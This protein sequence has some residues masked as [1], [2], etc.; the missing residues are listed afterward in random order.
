[1]QNFRTAA[2]P[3]DQDQMEI[4]PIAYRLWQ[5]AGRPPGR[6]KEF[7]VEAQQ[8]VMAARKAQTDAFVS[9][10]RGAGGPL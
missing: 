7:W 6:Y 4:A 10:A 2:D 8:R 1:M 3:S 9:A 5:A